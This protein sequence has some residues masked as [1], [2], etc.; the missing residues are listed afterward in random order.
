MFLKIPSSSVK[1]TILTQQRKYER[2]VITAGDVQ[3][4]QNPRNYAINQD[5]V[6]FLYSTSY[7]RKSQDGW[8]RI[9]EDWSLAYR[10]VIIECVHRKGFACAEINTGVTKYLISFTAQA[11]TYLAASSTTIT[12]TIFTVTQSSSPSYTVLRT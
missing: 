5:D 3:C 4:C 11:N 12:T 8:L 9:C 6:C 7:V 2:F 1:I 10:S